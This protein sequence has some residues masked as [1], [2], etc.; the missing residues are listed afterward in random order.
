MTTPYA[1]ATGG[2]MSGHGDIW[3][4]AEGGGEAG[5]GR[6]RYDHGHHD[7]GIYPPTSSRRRG[8]LPSL[9]ISGRRGAGPPPPP[10]PCKQ[11]TP[12]IE[13]VVRESNGRVKLV[14]LNIDDHPAI[15]GQMGIQSIPAVVAF[16]QG[17]AG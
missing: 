17:K 11:L 9:W 6:R 10:P 3:R 15:P 16:S 13:K 12:V 4:Q 2:Q 14:K 7:G 5:R 8:M 1:P